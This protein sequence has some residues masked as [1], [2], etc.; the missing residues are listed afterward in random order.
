MYPTFYSFLQ[1]SNLHIY[2]NYKMNKMTKY[3][4][5]T[6][7]ST[8]YTNFNKNIKKNWKGYILHI[9]IKFQNTDYITITSTTKYRDTKF[10]KYFS[11]S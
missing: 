9:K 10:S 1:T 11:I 7:A 2:V 4:K 3:P 8:N 5:H 6:N